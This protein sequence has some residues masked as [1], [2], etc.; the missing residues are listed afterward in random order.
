MFYWNL[1]TF[2]SIPFLL[3]LIAIYYYYSPYYCPSFRLFLSISFL[4]FL[5][6]NVRGLW[7]TASSSTKEGKGSLISS[8]ISPSLPSL[9]PSHARTS[10]FPP[11]PIVSLHRIILTQ[12]SLICPF[13]PFLPF[14]LSTLTRSSTVI[15][16]DLP[17]SPSV[18]ADNPHYRPWRHLSRN[19]GRR[20]PTLANV[21]AW[22]ILCAPLHPPPILLIHCWLM[23]T[24]N[25]NSSSRMSSGCVFG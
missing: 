13:S 1:Y 2:R 21:S 15:D 6:Y 23:S 14:S 7:V 3:L 8:F 11:P 24:A 18:E 12:S 20:W 17:L 4:S 19:I 25:S 16:W 5:F 22:D 9:S 10:H